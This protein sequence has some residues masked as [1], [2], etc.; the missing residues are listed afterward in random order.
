MTQ[1]QQKYKNTEIGTITQDWEVVRLGDISECYSGGT[2][3]TSTA[4]YYGGQI[5][6]IKSGEISQNFTEQTITNKGFANS[7]AK[8]ISKGNVL[9][10]LYGATSGECAIAKIDGAINQ[11]VLCIK[12]KISAEFL[13]YVLKYNKNSYLEKYLQGGQGNLSGEIVK[14]YQIPLPS[15]PEQSRIAKV[16][17]DTDALIT[18]LDKLIE[19]KKLIKQGA[20]E[21]LLT[22]KKS[23]SWKQVRLGDVCEIL[24]GQMITAKQY[25]AGEIPVIAGG[26]TPAGFHNVSNR[27]A[28]TVT[29]SASGA[30]AGF[31]AFHTE[32]IFAS[33][34]STI[35]ENEKYDV[36]YIYYLLQSRQDDIYKMQTGGAQPHIHPKNISPIKFF[37]PPKSEQAEIA[38][39]L[40]SM[41][42][43]ISALE[44]KKEKYLQI[45]S[46]MMQ[47]LLT[48]SIRLTKI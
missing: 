32:P 42:A 23:E 30:N 41:D 37:A 1:K 28:N 15:L 24:K 21:S 7:S 12:P 19:K 2:P 8:M 13:Y 5:P 36:K 31:V 40:S 18:A 39:V 6:L 10:A 20:M 38:N 35:S 3:N 17:S 14:S 45:K 48:G 33:D 16:L 34:C 25:V 4:S 44:Q 9:Y 47:E 22:P 46:G 27:K 26:K 29:I 11:A 43:E